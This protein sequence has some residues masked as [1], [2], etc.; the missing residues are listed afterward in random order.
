MIFRRG[1]IVGIVA[2]AFAAQS[3]AAAPP[4][5]EIVSLEGKGEYRETQQLD[6]KAAKINQPVFPSNL[7]RTGDQSKMA[8]LFPDR[9]Q[10]RLAQNSVLQIKE[11]SQG[12]DQKTI[13][14]LN[15]GRSWMQSKTSPGG[16]T[17][18]TPTAL[19]SIRGTDW[20]IVVDP[21]GRSTLTV[22]S[23]EAEFS[24]DQGRV[25]VGKNEQASAEKGRAPVKI[26]VINPRERIQWVSART[27][28]A[29][30]YRETNASADA[31]KELAAVARLMEDNAL[32]AAEKRLRAAIAI[33]QTD[34]ASARL[35]LAD[36]LIFDGKLADA[37]Q[38]L[39]VVSDK[40]PADVRA[41]VA[42]AQ[43]SLQRDDLP[44]AHRH[45]DEALRRAPNSIEALV[46]AGEIAHF[47]G[48]TAAARSAYTKA[49]AIAPNDARGWLGLG[50]IESELDN[51]NTAATYLEKASILDAASATQWGELATMQA[52]SGSYAKASQSF[53]K[54]LALQPDNYV[55]LTGKGIL[56]LK[57]GH[58]EEALNALLR[59][60]VIE[61]RYARAHLYT[62]VA[63]YRVERPDRALPELAKVIELD[64]HDPLPHLLAASIRTDDIEPLAAVQEAREANR[65][66][67]YLK[68]FNQVASNQ[69]GAANLG[70]AMS[71]FGME[72]WARS[73]AQE[74]YLPFWA[75]SHLFLA[76]RYAGDFN[77]RSELM[78]GFL[79]DPMVFGASNRYQSLVETPGKYATV[80]T[81]YNQSD[82]LKLVEPAITVNGYLLAPTPIAYFVEGI[83]TRIT[84][85]NTAL[86]ANARTF[87][88][89]LGIRPHW[90]S[91]FFIY[92]NRLSADIDI[93]ERNVTGTYQKVGGYNERV[94]AGGHYAFNARSQLWFKAGYGRERSTV[95]ELSSLVL[96]GL[97]LI[98]G[99]NF[100][101][102][103]TGADV[104][105]R[106]TMS[107]P[108]LRE[109]SWGVE[110]SRL[111]TS[112]GLV[113]DEGVHTPATTALQG[114]LNSA[115]RDRSA[116]TYGSLRTTLG[117]FAFESALGWSDYRKDRE[118]HV[119]SQ[120]AAGSANIFENYRVN[121]ANGAFGFVYREQP[122]RLLRF[123]CQEWTRPASNSTLAPVAVAGI[124]GDDQ[125]VFPGG[126]QTRCRGQLEWEVN[127]MTF[128]TAGAE[129]Q[130]I[131]NLYSLLD[132]VLNTRTDVTNLDRLRNRVL[133]LPPKPDALE[134]TSVFSLG[135]VARASLSM[136][137]IV[138]SS[139]AARFNYTYTDSAD[140]FADFRDNHLP[141]LARHQASIGATWTYPSRSYVSA[142]AVYRSERYI[143]EG[144]QIRLEP[145]WDMQVRAYVEFD[146]KHWSLEAYA[147]NLLKKNESDVFGV[148][149][150]YRF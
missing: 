102:Q 7:V 96:P 17:M 149:V 50:V 1:K 49:T 148:V 92:A 63:Y 28:D 120:S 8:L 94:D 86:K 72:N 37:Y 107:L 31:Q 4:A 110:A 112:N 58:N 89:A 146:R 103:P 136:E 5:A 80:S 124:P 3:F 134:D 66:M 64:A 65:L 104:Q 106:Q 108:G 121:R 34:S 71:F 109:I 23:G 127:A 40:Y 111:R 9:T 69:A 150:N 75:P 139:L 13:L 76:D 141:Y 61:P 30:R 132:G 2:I 54:A 135:E 113:Q 38:A 100:E 85:G 15:A 114:T 130:N 115:D 138:D 43:L 83:D 129:W 140:K 53:E 57:Q 143:D 118:F 52:N 62:A 32:G 21:D 116:L 59:A 145:G 39:N 42:L 14:N 82:D 79:L 12:K 19:A 142:Q 131:R 67:P 122:G 119:T 98:R 74:S 6:W 88:A 10:I 128:M 25:L 144:N 68:S 18:E 29:K 44:A 35:L 36:F 133:P 84:P 24:N 60:S 41:P 55:M 87:T 48:D 22:F 147:I 101:T 70:S 27:I 33:P 51:F 93:G 77:R 81:R 137:H 11:V 99:S 123:A 126:K 91:S 73:I 90:D 46:A 26:Q 16:L 20:E 56:E 45:I 117:A 78:Q 47:E 97:S 95:D 105:L 125:L